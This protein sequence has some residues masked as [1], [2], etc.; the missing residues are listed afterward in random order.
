MIHLKSD[1]SSWMRFLFFLAYLAAA[2]SSQGAEVTAKEAYHQL[3][4][5]YETLDSYFAVYD[6]KAP[7]E[8]ELTAAVT[9]HGPAQMAAVQAQ[10]KVKGEIVG[11]I[12]QA[13]TPE[14]GFF[15][16][17][18]Q[19]LHLKDTP[20]I[21]EKL[22]DIAE[23]ILGEAPHHLE[24]GSPS[25]YLT[26]ESILSQLSIGT[27]SKV[28]WC[29]EEI[30]EKTTYSEQGD[31][32]IFVTPDGATLH[33]QEETGILEF[34]SFPN[35]EGDRTLV[36]KELDV[37]LSE[38]EVLEFIRASL[39]QDLKEVSLRDYELFTSLQSQILG[40]FVKSGD[41]D[42]LTPERMQQHLVEAKPA[43]ADYFNASYPPEFWKTAVAEASV[44]EDKDAQGK[45]LK[46]MVAKLSTT[47]VI[48]AGQLNAKT[49]NGRAVA[50][51]IANT[52]RDEFTAFALAQVGF[53]E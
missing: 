20:L 53:P 12:F 15:M 28:P 38:E 47:Q 25:L 43:I 50:Q 1:S 13:Y 7:G 10:L 46:E 30:S 41:E 24:I 37:G 34:Q 35:E 40:V 45:I 14:L 51:V 21:V 2:V 18:P 11:E 42:K 22:F 17:G 3:L 32:A 52:F 44:N 49:D 33:I 19:V 31:L 8:K 5:N 29:D 36:L 9:F 6:S 16:S 39:P 4:E 26:K 48:K 27:S 23:S